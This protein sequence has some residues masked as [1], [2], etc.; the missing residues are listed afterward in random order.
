MALPVP[1]ESRTI[2]SHPNSKE[3]MQCPF[4]NTYTYSCNSTSNQRISQFQ[5][6]S[7]FPILFHISEFSSLSPLTFEKTS[8]PTHKNGLCILTIASRH[9][10]YDIP[11]LRDSPTPDKSTSFSSHPPQPNKNVP[12][13]LTPRDV[14]RLRHP[15]IVWIG[16]VQY[17]RKWNPIN[18]SDKRI[19]TRLSPGASH[20]F[21]RG[22]PAFP[23]FFVCLASDDG[24]PILRDSID[25]NI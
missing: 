14:P 12:R 20:P 8:H 15:L 24:V 1:T 3:T 13:L 17:I 6:I 4:H 21:I 16:Y 7:P 9:P 10:T 23:V 22:H 11:Q 5:W 2:L 19:P 25:R 18:L